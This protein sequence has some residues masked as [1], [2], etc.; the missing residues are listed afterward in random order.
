M[1]FVGDLR[2]IM[3]SNGQEWQEQ[4][5]FTL[6]NLRD[7]GFGK[8]SMEG[9]ILEEAEKCIDMLSHEVGRTSQIGLKMNIAILN[10]LWAILTG[11]KVSFYLKNEFITDHVV[12]DLDMK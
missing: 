5:R 4:R 12:Q 3:F 9:M 7:F 1:C 6:R 2:G 10:A 8:V 11:E